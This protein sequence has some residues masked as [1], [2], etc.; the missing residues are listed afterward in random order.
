MTSQKLQWHTCP[1]CKHTEPCI[2]VSKGG[3][4]QKEGYHYCGKCGYEWKDEEVK[5][6]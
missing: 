6:T 2:G 3:P 1:K 4:A 5:L